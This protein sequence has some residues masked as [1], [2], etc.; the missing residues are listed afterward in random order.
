MPLC[1]VHSCPK[2]FETS[3]KATVKLNTQPIQRKELQQALLILAKT[4]H[5]HK[6]PGSDCLASTRVPDAL[7]TPRGN[8]TA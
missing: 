3:R 4:N 1:C 8:M 7:G 6:I 5:P 2:N